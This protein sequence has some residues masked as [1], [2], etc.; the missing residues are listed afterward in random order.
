LPLVTHDCAKLIPV[1]AKMI[2]AES[3]S[4]MFDTDRSVDGSF[5]RR[6]L[7]VKSVQRGLPCSG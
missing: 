5:A 7:P 6:G 1:A 2:V 4:R 3:R